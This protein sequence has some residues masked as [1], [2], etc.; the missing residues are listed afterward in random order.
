MIAFFRGSAKSRKFFFVPISLSLVF[1]SSRGFLLIRL[2]GGPGLNFRG[3][4]AKQE[5]LE[6]LLRWLGLGKLN[7]FIH[8]KVK[9]FNATGQSLLM[10]HLHPGVHEVPLPEVHA[11]VHFS[12]SKV[13]SLTS[14]SS[15]PTP[16]PSRRH[17]FPE[18]AHP[19]HSPSWQG[20]HFSQCVHAAM[21]RLYFEIYTFKTIAI[22]NSRHHFAFRE[23][24]C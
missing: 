3:L 20:L 16:P 4:A 15:P 11:A 21:S 18:S 17:V 24:H 1:P 23:S 13:T 5:G 19:D 6:S 9:A 10:S 2:I 12:E 22:L 14:S 7:C 8:S